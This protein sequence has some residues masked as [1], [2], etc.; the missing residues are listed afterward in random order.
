MSWDTQAWAAK[1]RPGTSSAKLVLLALASCSDQKHC[2][3]PSIDWICDFSDLNRKTVISALQRLAS[4]LFPLISDTGKRVGKSGQIKVYLLSAEQAEESLVSR[5]PKSVQSRKGD[6]PVSSPEES[7]KRDTEPVLEP[8]TPSEDKSSDPPLEADLLGKGDQGE[9]D[10]PKR[11]KP[12][13]NQGEPI[14]AEWKPPAIS[15]L[16]ENA[17]ALAEQWPDG[18]YDA[19][20]EAFH[21]NFLAES[22]S[23]GRKKDWDR[24]W[25]VWLNREHSSVMRAKKAGV[26][27]AA[28]AGASSKP[29]APPK[30]VA[31]KAR[32]CPRSAAIHA[33]LEQRVGPK[34]YSHWFAPLA[35]VPAA[36]GVQVTAGSAYVRRYLEENHAEDIVAAARPVIGAAFEEVSFRHE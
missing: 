1:Q 5:V 18:A 27:F 14:S 33:A 13:R 29:A 8:I 22:R 19:V 16:P 4:G 25:V 26:S 30:P 23:I 31:A 24:A 36:R 11:A 34:T 17:R 7:Q 3:Y 35:I 32:E 20:A 15:D 2:A 28:M 6:S 12:A 10:P 21:S 9:T